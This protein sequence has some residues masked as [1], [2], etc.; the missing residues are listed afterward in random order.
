MKKRHYFFI[1]IFSY[2]L[3]LIVTLPASLFTNIINNNTPVTVQG[4]SGTLWNGKASFISIDDIANLDD[5]KWK[6]KALKLL[7]GR[8]T[9]QINTYFDEEK[10]SAELGASIF[11]QFFVNNFSAKVS[12]EKIAELADIPIAQLSGMVTLDIKHAHWKINELPLASGNII[13]D[14]ATI[15]V[16]ETV[17]LG[18]LTIAL[19]ENDQHF[20]NADITNKGGDLSLS[21]NA[22]LIPEKN[23][24]VNVK[25]SPTSSASPN[26]GNSLSLFSKKQRNGDFL[27][28][29]TGQLDQLGLQ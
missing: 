27:L 16:A 25:L 22:E 24:S 19:S 4:M 3:F 20:L 28:K 21:G 14:G 1:V 29:K 13:W 15:S 9:L 18:K 17:S 23:Y 12:S 6:L 10:V 8:A 2:F 11:K 5:T 26:I 7:T